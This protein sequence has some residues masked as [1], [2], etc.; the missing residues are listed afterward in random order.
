MTRC[1]YGVVSG[2]NHLMLTCVKSNHNQPR[3]TPEKRNAGKN[4]LVGV[5]R[6]VTVAGVVSFG[7]VAGVSL[8]TV[9]GIGLVV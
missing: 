4:L 5:R 8:V 2:L 3:I 6:G 7:V 9:A 1:R